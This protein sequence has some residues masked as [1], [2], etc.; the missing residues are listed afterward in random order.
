MDG[1]ICVRHSVEYL[2]Y[3]SDHLLFCLAPIFPCNNTKPHCFWM[4]KASCIY[5]SAHVVL[6]G[7]GTANWFQDQVYLKILPPVFSL[8]YLIQDP[9]MQF[10][11]GTFAGTMKKEGLFHC[12]C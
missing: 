12:S 9:E 6:G 1:L 8:K 3:C 7:A 2:Q 10:S 4:K 5:F 11:L